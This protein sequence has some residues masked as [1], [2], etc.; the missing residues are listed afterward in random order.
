V[1][2]HQ[3]PSL[4]FSVYSNKMFQLY[5]SICGGVPVFRVLSR[6]AHPIPSQQRRPVAHLIHLTTGHT[7]WSRPW[8]LTQ[9]CTTN[10]SRLA[11]LITYDTCLPSRVASVAVPSLSL[12]SPRRQALCGLYRTLCHVSH[13]LPRLSWLDSEQ[14]QS[15][16]MCVSQTLQHGN[17]M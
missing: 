7:W 8:R 16:Y 4:R 12:C 5:C 13:S 15:L 10:C 1:E 11:E 14:M 17:S 6:I 2:C 9:T 3:C